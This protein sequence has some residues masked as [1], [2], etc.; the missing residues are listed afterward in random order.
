MVAI[1]P[2]S[3]Y[4]NGS[5]GSPASRALI[6]LPTY[7]PSCIAGWAIPGSLFSDTMSPM[8]KTS[9]W[10]GTV[11]SGF[12]GM[13]PARSASTPGLLGQHLGQRRGLHAGRPDPGPG[14]DRLDALRAL[15]R[16]RLVVHVDGQG[17]HPDLDAHLLEALLGVALQLLRERRQHRRARPRTAGSAPPWCRPSG[18][19]GAARCAPARRSARPAPPRS[20]R[21]R[22]RR[23]SATRP[24][25]PGRWRSR[26]SRTWTGWCPGCT[27]RPPRS[28]CPGRTRRTGP[29]RSRSGWPRP[30]PPA[31][32]RAGPPRRPSGPCARTTFPARSRS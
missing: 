18:S 23:R 11:Q 25:P 14:P 2:L 32:R 5:T 3:K 6:T 19:P 22:S 30:P 9:G 27:G 4:L 13:R 1:V 12:T 15:H 31:C 16:D 7:L 17:V 26:P 29:C 28:S 21:P 10:P 24:V 20:G 8:A